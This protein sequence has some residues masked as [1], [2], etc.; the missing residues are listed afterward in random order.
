MQEKKRL[1]ILGCTG[2]IGVQA[3]EVIRENA[4]LFCAEVLVANSSADKLIEQAL[5]FEPN[6]V[7][8]ADE[9]Q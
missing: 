9:S 1:A 7:V 6:A 4:D 8:I 2:S 3:L 5:E